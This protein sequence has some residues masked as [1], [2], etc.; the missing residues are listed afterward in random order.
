MIALVTAIA[1]MR[2]TCEDREF[3]VLIRP[4]LARLQNIRGAYALVV[5]LQLR[6]AEQCE[7]TRRAVL[8][9]CT[10]CKMCCKNE[11]VLF[12]VER[13]FDHG[14]QRENSSATRVD[15]TSVNISNRRARF[16]VMPGVIAAYGFAEEAAGG[17]GDRN[18][19]YL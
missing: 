13:H 8:R 12:L 10:F 14:K 17:A 9:C 2:I 11:S 5:A 4:E 18:S 19:S 16:V 7:Q 3:G 1:I 6:E 15:V